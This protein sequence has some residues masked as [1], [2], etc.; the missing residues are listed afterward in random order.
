MAF[1][2]TP[3]SGE[4]PYTLSATLDYPESVNGVQYEAVVVYTTNVGS[5]PVTD[6]NQQLNQQTVNELLTSGSVVLN[7]STIADG[8]CRAFELQITRLSDNVV[9]SSE[10]ATIDNI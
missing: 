3:T 10:R 6:L 2:V 7:T 9:I 5:C 1:A 8:S 4:A